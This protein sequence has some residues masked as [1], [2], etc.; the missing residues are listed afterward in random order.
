MN[1][2][3]A[4]SRLSGLRDQALDVVR[5]AERYQRRG[6]DDP[7]DAHHAQ[8]QPGQQ[9]RPRGEIA[10]ALGTDRRHRPRGGRG[11][12]DRRLGG[13]EALDVWLLTTPRAPPAAADG[14]GL[15][16]SYSLLLSTSSKYH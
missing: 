13:C 9:L 6:R 14:V 10:V 16:G 3:P 12:D 2:R 8:R 7:L 11:R 1:R 5:A 15:R 4:T